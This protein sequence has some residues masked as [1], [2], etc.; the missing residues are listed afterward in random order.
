MLS[1]PLPRIA[2]LISNYTIAPKETVNNKTLSILG[3][4][5]R[6]RRGYRC[7]EGGIT[8]GQAEFIRVVRLA[9]YETIMSF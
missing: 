9:S 2:I 4:V 6:N 5:M 3:A 7:G 1:L 8:T